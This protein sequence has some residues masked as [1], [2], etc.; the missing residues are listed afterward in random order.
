MRL[1]GGVSTERGVGE[2]HGARR[3]TAPATWTCHGL[4]ERLVNYEVS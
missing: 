2:N 1:R 3:R 4:E